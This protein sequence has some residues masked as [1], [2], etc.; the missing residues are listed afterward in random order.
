MPGHTQQTAIELPEACKTAAQ[1]SAS[2]EM[3]QK[4]EKM[5]QNVSQATQAGMEDMMGQMN[6][7][8]KGLHEAMMEMN[9]PMSTGTMATDQDVAWICAMI[10][11]HQGAIAMAKAGLKGADNAESKKLAEKTIEENQKGLKELISWVEE[12]A[13]S[14]N[15]NEASGAK[16]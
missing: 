11:H 15:K 10:P 7:T 16:N 9:G 5:K 8:Q 13:Q 1:S 2:P 4:L 6:E 3:M 14:E 12:H